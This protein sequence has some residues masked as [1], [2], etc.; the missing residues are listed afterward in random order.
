MSQRVT[1][2][3]DRKRQDEFLG[4]VGKA[5]DLYAAEAGSNP[6][7]GKEIFLPES[8][9]GAD[10]HRMSVQPPCAIARIYICGHIKDPQDLKP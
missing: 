4:S 1:L 9:F 3:E 2:K 8:T 6:R 10:S 7:C 5:L